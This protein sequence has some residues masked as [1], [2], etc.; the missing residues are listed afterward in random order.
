MNYMLI[1]AYGENSKAKECFW[2][3]GVGNFQR[4]EEI[5]LSLKRII[6]LLLGFD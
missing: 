5:A 6:G 4:L 1:E 2:A 3:S